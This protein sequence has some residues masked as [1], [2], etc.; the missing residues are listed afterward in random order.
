[1]SSETGTDLASARVSALVV[2]Y[3]AYAELDVCLTSLA[4]QPELRSIV[5]VDQASIAPEREVL[6]RRHPEVRWLALD[7]NVGFGAGVN[8]AARHA[9]DE[10]LYLVNPDSIVGPGAI[11]VLTAWLDA[12]PTAAVAG[13]LVC[14]TDGT[15]QG[16]ARAFP[17]VSTFFAGRSSWLTRRF[18]TNRW[19]RRNVLTGPDVKAVQ[20]VDWVS[21]ASMMIR[22][23]AF[24]DVGGFDERYFLYWEDADLCRRLLARGWHTVYVPG[25]VVTHHGSRSSR[26]DVRPIVEFHRS[27]FRYYRTHSGSLGVMASPFAAVA[28]ALRLAWK[29]ATRSRE[30]E[31][32]P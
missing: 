11:G 6:E 28:L 10:Y 22:R 14:N 26:S 12:H 20:T 21:G 19:T 13:S 9:S 17:T 29:L 8:H 16:S 3:H 23:K 32:A 4:S 31:E 7:D 18:P 2:N 15:I 5:V 24:E 25:A 1:V 27:A 30:P